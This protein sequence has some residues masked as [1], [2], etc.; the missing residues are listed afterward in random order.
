MKKIIISLIFFTALV[1]AC[2][3]DKD[4]KGKV[5]IGANY[6]TISTPVRVVVFIDNEEKGTLTNP[7]NSVTDCDVSGNVTVELE[8]GT[9]TYKVIIIQISSNG[10][11][12]TLTKEFTI[13]KGDC[14]KFFID[15]TKIQLN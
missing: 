12:A 2:K 11:L 14:K 4:E 6:N 5:T 13:E 3:K 8:K 7:V 1:S 10:T 9:H 15:C